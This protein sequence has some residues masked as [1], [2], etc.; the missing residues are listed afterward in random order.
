MSAHTQFQKY[1]AEHFK[2]NSPKFSNGKTILEANYTYYTY[3]ML[4]WLNSECIVDIQ[5]E[6]QCP[7]S[8]SLPAAIYLNGVKIE[9]KRQGRLPPKELFPAKNS[10][11]NKTNTTMSGKNHQRTGR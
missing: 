5:I 10:T 9:Y 8:D 11:R 3:V 1:L 7:N 4:V 2:N 6:E